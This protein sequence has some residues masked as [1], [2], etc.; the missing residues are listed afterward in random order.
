MDISLC[1]RRAAGSPSRP[2]LS[3]AWGQAHR[4]QCPGTAWA[5]DGVFAGVGHRR[6][7]W[8]RVRRRVRRREP[9]SYEKLIEPS[10]LRMCYSSLMPAMVGLV[11]M[12]TR[13]L[14]MSPTDQVALG[15]TAPK[16][17]LESR[18]LSKRCSVV[19]WPTLCIKGPGCSVHQSRCGPWPASHLGTQTRLCDRPSPWPLA[20]HVLEARETRQTTSSETP[21]PNRNQCMP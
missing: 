21:R 4:G 19:I 15:C 2:I 16:P 18:T 13:Y 10:W 1:R 6:G 12:V 3:S 7:S 9:N 5:H 8:R 17:V 20:R 14:D 11:A